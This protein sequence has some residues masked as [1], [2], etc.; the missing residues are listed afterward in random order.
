M[1]GCVKIL[2]SS[3][4]EAIFRIAA[5]RL[6]VRRSV[7]SRQSPN[8]R[9]DKITTSSNSAANSRRQITAGW[10]TYFAHVVEVAMRHGSLAGR[11][12]D[13]IEQR[14]QLVL[15]RQIAQSSIA[16]RL[17]AHA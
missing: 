1:R 4:L 5:V 10:R 11:L 14:V 12:V 3:H 16:E 6:S 8:S 2:Y 9:M 17:T 7:S 13:V 15:G